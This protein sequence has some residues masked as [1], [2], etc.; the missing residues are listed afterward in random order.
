MYTQHFRLTELP[1]SIAPNPRYL[2]LS[3]QHREALAHLL[4]GIGVGGG[5]VVL[6]GEVGTGKTT[7]CRA[8]LD[9]LPKDVDIALIFN[10]RLNSREL[11]AGIC[12]ELHIP[13]AGPRASLKQ[14]IDALNQYLLESHAR[15]RR[16]IV[17]IDEAQNLRFDVLEQVRLL[18]NLETNQTKLLQIILVGQPELN[19]ILDRPNLRQLS[20]RITAR[21]HLNSLSLSETR[22]YIRHRMT[23]ACS[24][25]EV[26]SRP[27]ICAIHR[28]ARGIPRLIN[29]I[30]DRSLLGAYTLGKQRVSR[31]VVRRAADELMSASAK[32]NHCH[33]AGLLTF[34]L[35]LVVGVFFLDILPVPWGRLIGPVETASEDKKPASKLPMQPHVFVEPAQTLPNDPNSVIPQ[36]QAA[37]ESVNPTADEPPFAEWIA[38]SKNNWPNAMKSLVGEWSVTI[39]SHHDDACALAVEQGIRCQPI[40]IT[41]VQIKNLNLP[42][43]LEFVLPDGRKRYALVKS[44]MGDS[45]DMVFADN[46]KK[47]AESE[48][49]TLWT[50]NTTVAWKPGQ[51][52]TKTL[53][54]GD[55]SVLVAWVRQQLGV[56]ALSEGETFYDEPL[57]GKVT[58]F[59]K[60]R[61]LKADGII[62]TLTFLSLQTAG[63]SAGIPRLTPAAP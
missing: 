46:S 58:E 2:Y 12:D 48:L 45:V 19:Q 30:A 22:D 8:L 44:V 31:S 36:Q 29:L 40:Q 54:P 3:P 33:L 53:K 18:T 35:S 5:F 10:P 49:L 27:A 43:V 23:G 15:G 62:G 25:E 7:L 59:Q 9:Q 56:T 28:K 13:Y 37:V 38:S 24:S 61:G 47:F 26:F 39:P 52:E 57:R 16:V 20:Q 55:R 63:Q 34:V 11:L 42:V 50:G 32:G 41:W 14:L 4:Y 21:Y 17:L 1:F 6:T 51:A 60:S